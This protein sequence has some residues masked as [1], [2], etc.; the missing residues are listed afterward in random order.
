MKII[1]SPGR[2]EAVVGPGYFRALNDEQLTA[3]KKI[4]GAVQTGNDREFDLWRAISLQG[5]TAA[6]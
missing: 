3:A 4:Y 5:T 2:G 6:G 1:S